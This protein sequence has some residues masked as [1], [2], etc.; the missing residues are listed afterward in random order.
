MSTA[1]AEDPTG[2]IAPHGL[3]R[4]TERGEEA[5]DAFATDLAV[6]CDGTPEGI[7]ELL[8]R[9]LH[10]DISELTSALTV[11]ADTTDPGPVV[12]E[13]LARTPETPDEAARRRLDRH[14]DMPPTGDTQ[15]ARSVDR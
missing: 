9:V 11:V 14:Q 2:G 10:T 8:D 4:F 7:A 12:D 3:V 6:S 15:P 13:H 5:L 1:P